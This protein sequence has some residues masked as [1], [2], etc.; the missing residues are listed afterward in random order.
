SNMLETVQ[1]QFQIQGL[2][3]DYAIVC[4]D[5]DL[6]RTES[7]WEA[8]KVRG[9]QWSRDNALEVAKNGYRVLLTRARK[10]MIVF[11]PEGDASGQ[12]ET[13]NPRFYDGIAA[14]L[15]ACGAKLLA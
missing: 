12:D 15:M 10:G 4:W 5:A 1:N 8:W 7:G 14:H 13:R 6:R 11:V 3:I 9:A 2:E